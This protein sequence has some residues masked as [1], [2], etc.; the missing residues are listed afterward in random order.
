MFSSH[1][2]HEYFSEL[3][4]AF[5][6]SCCF[7]WEDYLVERLVYRFEDCGVARKALLVL[8]CHGVVED[9]DIERVHRRAI[10]ARVLLAQN[11]AHNLRLLQDVGTFGRYYHQSVQLWYVKA[12]LHN[13]NDPDDYARACFSQL[14]ANSANIHPAVLQLRVHLVYVLQ[15]ARNYQ[16]AALWLLVQQVTQN[17]AHSIVPIGILEDVHKRLLKLQLVLADNFFG[18]LCFV[19]LVIAVYEAVNPQ[20]DST[21][22]LQRPNKDVVKVRVVEVVFL[23]LAL[24]GR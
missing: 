9:V 19:E 23:V 22:V 6:F 15:S 10:L 20:V 18:D 12:F 14:P 2:F 5:F 16:H 24:R 4:Q 13:F 3:D 7:F 21:L 11:S 1:V 8:V 17:V